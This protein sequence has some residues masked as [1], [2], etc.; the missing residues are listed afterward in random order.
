MIYLNNL[1]ELM[2]RVVEEGIVFT[3][4]KGR[5]G[6]YRLDLTKYTDYM[7]SL[8]FMYHAETKQIIQYADDNYPLV[9]FDD[10]DSVV[11]YVVSELCRD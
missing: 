9:R 3:V 2:Q 6:C 4:S 11:E 1:S 10:I 8:R 7:R 5:E